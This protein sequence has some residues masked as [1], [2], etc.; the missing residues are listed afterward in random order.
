LVRAGVLVQE[1]VDVTGRDERQAGRLGELGELGVHP[2]LDVE[3]SVLDLDVGRVAP[4]DLHE[5]VEV[6]GGVRRPVLLESLADAARE[7]AGECDKA[8]RVVLEQL[9]VDA[10]LVVIALQVAER[11]E[12]DQVRVALVRLGEDGQVS[13]ALLLDAPVFGDIDLA[14]DHR[15]H[16]L[17]ARLAVELDRAGER[18]V[19]GQRDRGHL[20]L[21]GA[22]GEPRD[23]AGAVE[24]RV[25]AVDVEVDEGDSRGHGRVILR[26]APAGSRSRGPAPRFLR[27]YVASATIQFT[28]RVRPN[29]SVASNRS[30]YLP[31]ASRKGPTV[32]LPARER[33]W[34]STSS[35]EPR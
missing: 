9:P 1:V 18:A 29:G 23:A 20:E 21:C 7:A 17:L 30:V 11:R 14:A 15:L 13:V 8:L 6:G 4:E 16:A 31:G 34:R 24:D 5:P 3:M 26:P 22:L 2:L 25:L 35:F 27:L 19:V 32:I 33:K 10:R 28:W 12:L